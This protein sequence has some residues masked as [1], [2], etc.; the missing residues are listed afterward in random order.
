[1][2]L[3]TKQGKWPWGKGGLPVI[4]KKKYGFGLVWELQGEGGKGMRKG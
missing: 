2:N 4:W 3:T 1:M